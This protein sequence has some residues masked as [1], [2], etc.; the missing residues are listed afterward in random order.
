ME[1]HAGDLIKEPLGDHYG[2]PM[3]KEQEPFVWEPEGR[4][5][6]FQ[7]ISTSGRKIHQKLAE[8]PVVDSCLLPKE[9]HFGLEEG[10]V[11]CGAFQRP[12]TQDSKTV[13]LL[14]GLSEPARDVPS[15]CCS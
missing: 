13:A 5:K 4:R 11:A 9:Q 3:V 1:E 14:L 8:A 15:V 7:E 6:T 12:Q 10:F 2:S